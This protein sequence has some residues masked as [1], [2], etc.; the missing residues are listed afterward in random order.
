MVSQINHH[1]DIHAKAWNPIWVPHAH[2]YADPNEFNAATILGLRGLYL[3][4]PIGNLP[5]SSYAPSSLFTLYN[6]QFIPEEPRTM[7]EVPGRWLS[8]PQVIGPFPLLSHALTIPSVLAHFSR[9]DPL[10]EVRC[11]HCSNLTITPD[12]LLCT[13]CS[14][15]FHSGC[16]G[17]FR[18]RLRFMRKTRVTSLRLHITDDES[19]PLPVHGAIEDDGM[20]QDQ[21]MELVYSLLNSDDVRR[22][23]KMCELWIELNI[24]RQLPEGI[25][26]NRRDLTCI[27][28]QW[29]EL[30]RSGAILYCGVVEN[31]ARAMEPFALCARCLVDHGRIRQL[32]FH[33]CEKSKDQPDDDDLTPA[34]N[35]TQREN[36]FHAFAPKIQKLIQRFD[37]HAEVFEKDARHWHEPPDHVPIRRPHL[38][39][40]PFLALKRKNTS[41]PRLTQAKAKQQHAKRARV[42]AERS[43]R[44]NEEEEEEEEEEGQTSRENTPPLIN[45]R[46]RRKGRSTNLEYQRNEWVDRPPAPAHLPL[47][48]HT[49][50]ALLSS[51]TSRRSGFQL[52]RFPSP[53]S[54]TDALLAKSL[55]CCRSSIASGLFSRFYP[56]YI[57]QELQTEQQAQKLSNLATT[58]KVTE[59]TEEQLSQLRTQRQHAR[60][61]RCLN[62][63]TPPNQYIQG[64]ILLHSGHVATFAVS[65]GRDMD[66]NL[67]KMLVESQRELLKLIAEN[68]LGERT[69][70]TRFVLNKTVFEVDDFVHITLIATDDDHR[71]KGLAK[72]LLLLELVRWAQRGRTRA[73]VQ[74]VLE[75]HSPNNTAGS[76]STSSSSSLSSS[77]IPMAAKRRLSSLYENPASSQLY[78]SCGFH[79]IVNRVDPHTG[80]YWFKAQEGDRG[81]LMLNL[82]IIETLR[83]H[84]GKSF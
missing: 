11:P 76:T 67:Q 56:F 45:P 3:Y 66:S 25:Q 72:R 42:V 43:P 36:P 30:T 52:L 81:R 60:T 21:A 6:D 44:P 28:G 13:L 8:L 10:Y 23:V 82:D 61:S 1:P 80:E 50:S 29:Y 37:A 39:H 79:P 4:L 47:L 7:D 53:D 55:H 65:N 77:S 58:R 17:I 9:S 2:T 18:D 46:A 27:S 15:L 48:A 51:L 59:A 57:L 70:A 33:M 26:T 24:Q 14:S 49:H 83:Q 78:L 63:S 34:R 31:T 40:Y 69:E 75:K 41:L 71:G 35:G 16:A 12:I 64:T 5:H 20:D 68:K 74:M 19:A 38:Q 84:T 22:L 54:L 62:P 73:Y 32:L